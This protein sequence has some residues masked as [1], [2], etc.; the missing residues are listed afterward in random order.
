[1]KQILS[2][3]E[4]FVRAQLFSDGWLGLL[5]NP[6]H[7]AR[8]GLLRAIRRVA[9]DVR[10]GRLL[11]VGCGSQPYRSYFRVD[12]YVGMEIPRPESIQR[13]ECYYDGQIFPFADGCFDTVL[14]SQVLEHVFE[15]QLF[16]SEIRRALRPGGQLILTVP[17][18]WDEHEQPWD[19]ARYSTFG[20]RH[21]L[22][23]H[24]FTV[25]RQEKLGADFSALAQLLNGYLFKVTQTPWRPVNL[26]C[27]VCL[28]GP[29]NVL[30]KVAAAI[31]PGNPDLFL[32]QLVVAEKRYD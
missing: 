21:L 12:F 23:Q 7:I 26:L 20:L 8:S 10:G 15:P 3:L 17:F 25:L 29:V 4:G 24:G 28:M 22:E 14:A 13:V 27:W 32:D 31:L 18:A 9:G 2:W 19:F 6:F 1:M 11:D 5:L 30:G 16:L